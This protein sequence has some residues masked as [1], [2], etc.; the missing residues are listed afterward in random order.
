MTRAFWLLG[1]VVVTSAAYWFA[2][3]CSLLTPDQRAYRLYEDGDYET[4]AGAFAD[5][6]WRGVSLYRQG[7]FAQAGAV[8]A[9]Y[10][11][12]E[13]AFNQG[14]ALARRLRYKDAVDWYERSLELRPN[15]EPAMVNL[16]I[17]R[18]Y[19]AL[20]RDDIADDEDGDNN[21]NVK[22]A[23]ESGLTDQKAPESDQNEDGE[24]LS[25]VELREMW[26]RQVQTKPADFLRAKFLYQHAMQDSQ[27]GGTE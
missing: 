15:W 7:E 5:P 17:A 2:A 3:D 23:D 1:L 9:G 16:D 19:A 8:F 27:P 26:L 21:G 20:L 13:A 18:G 25:D 24:P 10:D 14:N 4:A 22:K 11:T 6:M 12:A